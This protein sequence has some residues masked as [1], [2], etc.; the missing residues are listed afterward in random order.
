MMRGL[1]T[2]IGAAFCALCANGCS[3][4]CGL[5]TQPGAMSDGG[6]IAFSAPLGSSTTVNVPIQ[7]SADADETV[8]GSALNG[9]D[10]AAF[11]VLSTFPM[12]LPAGTGLAVTVQFTPLHG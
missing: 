1:A 5:I 6:F 12:S 3:A 8:T 2:V 11:K 10:V 7:D 9:S 4:Q